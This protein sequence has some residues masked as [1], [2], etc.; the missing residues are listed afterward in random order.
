MAKFISSN[1]SESAIFAAALRVFARKG[2]DG[3]RM[4]E[5]ADA[6]G[7]NKAMLH[8]YFRSKDKL[9]EAVFTHVV[10][11]FF[12]AIGRV[13]QKEQ[14]FRETLR[15]LID[16]YM[17]EHYEHPDMHRMWVH[18]NL[19]GAPVARALVSKGLSAQDRGGPYQLIAR[20]KRAVD[21]GEIRPVDPVQFLM[22]FLGMTLFYFIA[23]PTL[24]VLQPEMVSDPIGALERRKQHVFEVLYH[25][26]SI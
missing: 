19:N 26:V 13:L 18:E 11:H 5:I 2:K 20:I 15:E 9:Y 4:Q 7:I 3:A 25:G 24:S 22:S 23:T 8:Y 14:P 6:A 21:E 16:V 1:E 17:S 10:A 12:G